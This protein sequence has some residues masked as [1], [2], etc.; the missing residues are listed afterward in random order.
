ML[1]PLFLCS[2]HPATAPEED[3][4]P[5]L[6]PDY[7]FATRVCLCFFIIR[8]A[9]DNLRRFL[10]IQDI[11]DP[12]YDPTGGKNVGVDDMRPTPIGRPGDYPLEPSMTSHEID[13]IAAENA[14]REKAAA[15]Y[16][17]RIDNPVLAE[18]ELEKRLREE[19]AKQVELDK[20]DLE[21]IRSA[22]QQRR[23]QKVEAKRKIFRE[24]YFK[25][26]AMPRGLMK[27]LRLKQLNFLRRNVV[28]DY[29]DLAEGE[30]DIHNEEERKLN[31]ISIRQKKRVN[32]YNDAV[33]E[34][35]REGR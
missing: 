4:T 21:A 33:Q 6:P 12:L 10:R 34:Q 28:L 22:R 1:Y 8:N 17:S 20:K 31:E 27:Y 26:T 15:E 30:L 32:K 25:T 2:D 11:F 16:L 9:N 13:E 29:G 19:E 3:V 14:M 5:Y 24:L 7:E 23:A 18:L 35:I